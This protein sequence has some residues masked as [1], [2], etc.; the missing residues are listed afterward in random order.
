MFAEKQKQIKWI[1]NILLF[2]I[3]LF[4]KRKHLV[5]LEKI[6]LSIKAINEFN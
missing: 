3:N 1:K 6:E 4:C 5:T 2:I